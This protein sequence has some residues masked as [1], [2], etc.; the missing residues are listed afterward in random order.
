MPLRPM[1]PAL[2]TAFALSILVA[3]LAVARN[4]PVTLALAAGLFAVQVIVVA[5]RIMA[6]VWRM[7]TT[8]S[9]QW[10]WCSTVLAALVYAWGSAAMFGVYSLTGL[11]WRHW[12]QYGAGLAL[13]SAA[14]LVCAQLLASGRGPL[15]TATSTGILMLL[16]AL[17]AAGMSAAVIYIVATG[18]LLSQRPDWAANEIFVVGALTLALLSFLSLVT[19]WLAPSRTKPQPSV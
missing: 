16:T 2:L 17:Q 1:L 14:T 5:V 18:K 11:V 19:N 3:V 9:P 10:T 12:W 6:P 4:A 15:S 13:F 8:S 7:G